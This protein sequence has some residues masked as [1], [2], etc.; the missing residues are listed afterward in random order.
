M[1]TY[2]KISL[3]ATGQKTIRLHELQAKGGEMKIGNINLTPKD[4]GKL[5]YTNDLLG[6]I[7]HWE[8]GIIYLEDGDRIFPYQPKEVHWLFAKDALR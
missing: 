4:H 7:H 1:K 8:N 3:Y 6:K 5:V 2:L